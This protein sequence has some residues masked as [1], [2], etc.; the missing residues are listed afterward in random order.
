[1][2]KQYLDNGPLRRPTKPDTESRSSSDMDFKAIIARGENTNGQTSI[3]P[4]E[5]SR[6]GQ[7]AGR[8]YSSWNWGGNTDGGRWNSNPMLNEGDGYESMLC[9][10]SRTPKKK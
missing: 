2:V 9:G 3:A 6:G 7:T 5:V 8:G 1:M 10:I 4:A